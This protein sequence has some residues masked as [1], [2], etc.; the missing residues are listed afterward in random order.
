MRMTFTDFRHGALLLANGQ[1]RFR[2]WA[3]MASEVELRIVSPRP[4]AVALERRPD[5]WWEVSLEDV[6]AGTRYAYRLDGGPERPDPASR[7]QPDGVH[8]PSELMPETFEW[9][10]GSW[11]GFPLEQ[12]VL[13][14]L[15][16]GTFTREGTFDAI[17]PHLE[18]L[19][20]L[21]VTIVELMPVAQFPGGRNWGYDGVHPF[22]VQNSSGGPQGL[23]RL[24]NAC[25]RMGLGVA[26]DVVY[27]HLGPEGNYLGEFG[28]YFTGAYRTPWGRAINFDGPESDEVRRFFIEN[29]LYWI[30]EFHFDA[31]RLDAVHGIFDCTAYTFLEELGDA[32]HDEASRLG[33]QVHVIPESDLNDPR[34]VRSKDRGGLGLDVQWADGFHHSLRTLLTVTDLVKA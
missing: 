1:A 15:H 19:R 16:T 32:I 13:Y 17:H 22:A 20:D 28:P 34:L 7:S 23:K 14:E 30:R 21:G 29:A 27:N 26:L 4:A 31:L 2:V 5:G 33:R 12:C 3:P 6:P 25:H 18:Y 24:V 10:D 11:R 8:A 9:Q